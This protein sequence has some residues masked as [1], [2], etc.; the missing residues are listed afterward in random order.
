MVFFV[1]EGKF[2]LEVDCEI[3]VPRVFDSESTSSSSASRGAP[4]CINSN[5][6]QKLQFGKKKKIEPRVVDV[7]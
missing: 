7:D 1:Y 4:L 6:D 2:Q 3:V 5:P